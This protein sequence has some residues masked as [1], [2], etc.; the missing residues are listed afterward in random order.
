VERV[1]SLG[2]RIQYSRRR[3]PFL[4]VVELS[5]IRLEHCRP[6]VQSITTFKF[7]STWEFDDN[8]LENPP[9]AVNLDPLTVE[10][11]RRM[12]ASL[13]SLENLTL[14]GTFICPDID[15]H[16]PL[17]LPS[18][19]TL[20]IH[21]NRQLSNFSTGLRT[22][23]LLRL[24]LS[25]M[26]K[27]ETCDYFIYILQSPSASPFYPALRI[28]ELFRTPLPDDMHENFIRSFSNIVDLTL[29]QS[30]ESAFL[31]A[32]LLDSAITTFW[33]HLQTLTLGHVDMDILCSLVT[34]WISNLAVSVSRGC[35]F[36][37]FLNNRNH[38]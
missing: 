27:E 30:N 12:I 32:L 37:R 24:K 6:P 16:A 26:S 22:S 35:F 9:E 18:L 23:A 34:A 8:G 5:N 28:L 2:G 29:V 38:D 11:F 1:S 17:P 14:R 25:G 3:Y 15:E 13:P 33:L 21:R 7:T 4:K 36:V 31:N 19:T 10:E 20:E